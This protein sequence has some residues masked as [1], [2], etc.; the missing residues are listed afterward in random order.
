MLKHFVA[1]LL[2]LPAFA[3]DSNALLKRLETLERTVAE[4][5]SKITTLEGQTPRTTSGSAPIRSTPADPIE[6]PRPP[7]MRESPAKAGP[8]AFSGDFRVFFDA[9]TRPSGPD[10]P[11]VQNIRGRYA[12]RLDMK[13]DVHRA[14]SFHGRLATGPLS[15]P[16]TEIQDFGGGV[17]KHPF[18]V[19]E[20]YADF[21]PNK[22]VTLQAGRV[23]SPFN[24]RS[25]LLFDLDTRFNG[26]NEIFRFPFRSGSK[27][28][29]IQLIA[30]Q[31]TFSNPN[32]AAIVPGTPSTT[33]AATPSQAFL[34]AGAVPGTQP[35]ASQLFQQGAIVDYQLIDG[36]TQQSEFDVQIYRNPNQLRLMSL[37]GGLFLIGSA[38]GITPAA[39]VPS[40]GN[41]TTTPG[42]AMLFAPHYQI[43]HMSHTIGGRGFRARGLSFPVSANLQWSRNFGT[44]AD[45]NALA[46]IFSAG[47]TQEAGDLRF[48]YAYYRKEANSLISELTEFDIAIG[49]NV[50]M[51][52]HHW[53]ADFT[54]ARGV[55][56]SNN[57]FYT[58][59]LK[60]SDPSRNF[61][62]PF[63]RSTPGQFRYQGFLQLRF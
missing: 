43:G 29:Q 58:T 45:R 27:L 19:Q 36:I 33:A 56:F 59:W 26:T 23:D 61:Y 16:L 5:Q 54:F 52:A 12:L 40:P 6:A 63:G 49:N 39:V 62:V 30:T 17:A 10:A 3:A 48:A 32:F 8:I 35:R 11:R 24:D 44:S 25:R 31:Y 38:T 46:A 53:R 13:A 47:R 15:N 34:A 50:N 57:F 7:A 1:F 42:G 20:A 55:V 22:H 21:H 9:L 41:A 14:I 4:L 37:A 51:Q 60:N 28:K 2:A 18:F